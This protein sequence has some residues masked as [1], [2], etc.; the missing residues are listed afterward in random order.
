MTD[1]FR[2]VEEDVRRERYERLWKKYGDYAI[3]GAAVVVIAVAGFQLW[4][5]YDQRQRARTSDAYL[6]AQQLFDN[7]QATEAEDA[8]AKLQKDAPRGYAAVAKLQEA[9][10]MVAAGNVADAVVIYK[11]IAAGKDDILAGTARIRAGWALVDTASKSDVA[12]LLAPLAGATN[13][14]RAPARE[15][16]AYADFRAGDTKAALGEYESLATDAGAPAQLRVRSDWMATFL[17]AGGEK[18][19]GTVPL[20]PAPPAAPP[21]QPQAA[22]GG[23]PPK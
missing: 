9:D 20:P 8:F 3:A 16:L 17:K 10:A 2:E 13:P 6:A 21:S 22:A 14:W 11:Q 12:A 7:G 15:I 18:N 19:Y 5:V 1:I 23:S 4:R